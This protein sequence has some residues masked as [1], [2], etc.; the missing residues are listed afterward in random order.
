MTPDITG[1][2]ADLDTLAEALAAGEVDMTDEQTTQFVLAAAV[3]SGRAAI[4]L[5]GA[6]DL[7][8]PDTEVTEAT[9]SGP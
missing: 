7:K 1:L 8:R 2:T 5:T 3:A 9:N 4:Y 6:P